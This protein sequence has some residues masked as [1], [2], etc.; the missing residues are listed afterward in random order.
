MLQFFCPK[1]FGALLFLT[2]IVEN[3]IFSGKIR[4]GK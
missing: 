3:V 1:H 4:Y 2:F